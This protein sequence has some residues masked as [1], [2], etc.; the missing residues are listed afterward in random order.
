MKKKVEMTKEKI[1]AQNPI[2]PTKAIGFRPK[3]RYEKQGKG[4]LHIWD[5]IVKPWQVVLCYPEDIPVEYKDCFKCLDDEDLQE[6]AKKE[7]ERFTEIECLY[8]LV[9]TTRGW[10]DVV[11]SSTGKAINE[12]KL[13]LVDAQE[14]KESLNKV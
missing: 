3:L 10:Y 7:N 4:S 6:A 11:N 5:S 1:P 8:N 12:K 14:L 2:T 13:R 9:E